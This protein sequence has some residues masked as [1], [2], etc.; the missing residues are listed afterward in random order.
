MFFQNKDNIFSLNFQ[1]NNKYQFNI[2]EYITDQDITNIASFLFLLC[3][4]SPI[5]VEIIDKLKQ[6][7]NNKNNH[8][9]DKILD[10]WATFYINDKHK[11]MIDPLS[12]F[13]SNV[14]NK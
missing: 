1:T 8:I 13:K 5:S 2:S 11:P 6:A 7:K 9:I 12:A 14:N 10:S 4:S 3:Y